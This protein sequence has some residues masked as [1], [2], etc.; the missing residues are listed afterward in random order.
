V[1]VCF[2]IWLGWYR[3]AQAAL[4]KRLSSQKQQV[5][6]SHQLFL[7]VECVVMLCDV[8]CCD[9]I[10]E[11]GEGKGGVAGRLGCYE[12]VLVWVGLFV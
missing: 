8:M 7:V 1:I 5:R 6:E 10:C 9:V 4:S 2:Q 3:T 11:A 12:L